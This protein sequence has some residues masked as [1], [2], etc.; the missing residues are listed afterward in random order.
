VND[1][2][3]HWLVQPESAVHLSAQ[4]FVVEPEQYPVPAWKL[5]QSPLMVQANPVAVQLEAEQVPEDVHDCP[6]G[7]VPQVPPHPSEPQT[8]PL[9]A[10]VH[11]P[12]W[13]A[14]AVHVCDELHAAQDRPVLPQALTVVPASQTP[15][16]LQQP[17]Q[18][19]AEHDEPPQA[20]SCTDRPRA[21][22]ADKTRILVRICPPNE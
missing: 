16:V 17:A 9:Q 6:L 8:L 14:P 10:G 13:Q 22:S 12:V 3:Q 2:S 20:A 11:E 18:L 7:Q 4:S 1:V 21:I 19:E 5:Q 15:E